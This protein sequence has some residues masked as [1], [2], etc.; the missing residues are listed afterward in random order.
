M[1]YGDEELQF[2][3]LSGGGW[4]TVAVSFKKHLVLSWR[5]LELGA[6]AYQPTVCSYQAKDPRFCTTYCTEIFTFSWT[7]RS[8]VASLP[9]I[10][11]DR[12]RPAISPLVSPRTMFPRHAVL[13]LQTVSPLTQAPREAAGRPADHDRRWH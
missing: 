13:K 8:L 12:F 1:D 10:N 4:V 3:T 11:M 7:D 5:S 9:S 2:A 6:I